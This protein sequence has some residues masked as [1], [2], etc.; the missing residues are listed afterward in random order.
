MIENWN[1]L[2]AVG[3]WKSQGT[4]GW[5]RVSRLIQEPTFKTTAST[6]TGIETPWFPYSTEN[7][8]SGG[9]IKR[10]E[11]D[12]EEML[13]I[14]RIIFPVDFR[15]TH[16][17]TKLLRKQM[18]ALEEQLTERQSQLCMEGPN[19][20][21]EHEQRRGGVVGA[22][23]AADRKIASSSPTASPGRP[24]AAAARSPLRWSPPPRKTAK[25]TGS[26]RRQ[27]GEALHR[28]N[29]SPF[30][31]SV[32][33]TSVLPL[34]QL[35]RRRDSPPPPGNVCEGT[36]PPTGRATQ[37]TKIPLRRFWVP[38]LCSTSEGGFYHQSTAQT[39]TNG[40]DRRRRGLRRQRR[41]WRQR[42]WVK[43]QRGPFPFLS[44]GWQLSS[45]PPPSTTAL[46]S[47]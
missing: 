2:G 1:S 5:F 40:L 42:R 17:K 38:T 44:R 26:P 27:G 35:L 46:P 24:V 30:S 21:S 15:Y 28:G 16:R 7:G 18:S 41:Q 4:R 6:G 39:T 10:G 29:P 37:M 23:L 3:S 31:S 14:I 13:R 34:R 19:N 33:S 8:T 36:S 22:L 9:L 12:E 47:S 45:C 11:Q 20:I 25:P 43:D 32:P